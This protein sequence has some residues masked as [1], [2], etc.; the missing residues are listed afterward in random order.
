MACCLSPAL[1][2]GLYNGFSLAATDDFQ[3]YPDA[4]AVG[5]ITFLMPALVAVSCLSPRG[6]KN[7]Q[8]YVFLASFPMAMLLNT[9]VTWLRYDASQTGISLQY[10]YG[11]APASIALPLGLLL[12]TRTRLWTYV[13]ATLLYLVCKLWLLPLGD[14]IGPEWCEVVGRIAPAIGSSDYVFVTGAF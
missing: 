13:L 7:L 11:L 6:L 14:T 9:G 8:G 2:Q 3:F 12:L 5:V 10:V 4:L 1:L